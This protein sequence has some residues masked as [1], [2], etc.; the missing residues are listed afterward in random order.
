MNLLDLL[1]VL[2]L[3]M[4]AARGFR[5][6]ALSQVAAFGGAGAGLVAGAAAAP[7]L[8]GAVVDQPGTRLALVTF[9]LL[10]IAVLVGQALGL[11]VGLRL[12][13]AAARAGIGAL[14]RL[15]G[16]LVSLT[17]LVVVAWL[18]GSML[19]Q[20][21]L[22]AVAQQVQG[23]RLLT[24]LDDQLPP[25]PDLVGR[26]AGFLD[27]QG[28]PQVFS[29]MGGPITAPP[30]PPTSDAAVQA[31]AASGQ[32]STVQ[33]RATGCGGISAGS[34][35]VTAP[36]FVVTNAHVIAGTGP[37][38]VRDVTGE[39]QAA[40]VHF[41]AALDLTVLSA[42]TLQAPPLGWAGAPAARGAEGATLGF[43]GGQQAMVVKPATVRARGEAVGRD[44]Y[45]RGLAPREILTL[46]AGVE[47]GDSGGPFVTADGLVGGV[48]FA[49]NAARPGEGYALT[50]ERVRPDVEAAI[51]R[52]E[53]VGVGT[54][55]F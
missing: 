17:G 12:R 38:V 52:N 9:G 1:L 32:A 49:A 22:P 8:A 36:G 13:H 16:V 4:A 3:L 24:A 43:P 45:G 53:Q 5:Q 37:I 26:I 31:A 40:P 20:G 35:F 19:S 15:V 46:A 55:R 33:V 39:H 10:L 50:A 6:G 27:Q 18:L 29:G 30:V 34:G 44:I 51:A 54:C 7:E 23:S 42:P 11:A 28:F 25:P 2:A 48:V 21:P 41:D 47:R 14:D